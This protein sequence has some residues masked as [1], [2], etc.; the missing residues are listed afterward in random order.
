[1]TLTKLKENE[2][3]EFVTRVRSFLDLREKGALDNVAGE[4]RTLVD[5]MLKRYDNAKYLMEDDELR[6]IEKSARDDADTG[7][8]NPPYKSADSCLTYFDQSK[9]RARVFVYMHQHA[10]RVAHS[11]GSTPGT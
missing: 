2:G 4:L 5:S 3:D 11:A 8:F 7:I 1:M 6:T 10:R 9:V